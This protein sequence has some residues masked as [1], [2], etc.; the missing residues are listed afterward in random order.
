MRRSL[1]RDGRASA[2]ALLSS[3]AREWAPADY[4]VFVGRTL[5]YKFDTLDEAMASAELAILAVAG[6]TT[7]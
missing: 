4:Q 7:G 1:G 2:G 6:E 5:V 3:A